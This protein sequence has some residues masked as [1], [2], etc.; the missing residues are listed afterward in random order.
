MIVN[1]H[2]I[3]IQFDELDEATKQLNTHKYI[4]QKSMTRGSTQS[5]YAVYVGELEPGP[6]AGDGS[7][8][9]TAVVYQFKYSSD[10]NGNIESWIR[11]HAVAGSFKDWT[12][13]SYGTEN[14]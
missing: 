11:S 9:E 4:V 6:E 12:F 10:H 3:R 13:N 7:P 2:T 5:T 1:N 8:G 14:G